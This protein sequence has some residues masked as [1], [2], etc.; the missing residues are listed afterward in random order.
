LLGCSDLGR[1]AA[2]RYGVGRSLSLGR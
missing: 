2:G 1:P